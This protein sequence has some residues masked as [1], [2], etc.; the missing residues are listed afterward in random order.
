MTELNTKRLC[1]VH[2]H[3][4]DFEFDTAENFLDLLASTG[5]TDTALQALCW[6]SPVENLSVL[7]QKANY[8]KMKLSAFGSIHKIDLYKD[9]PFEKQAKALFDMGCDGIKLLG[10]KP[11]ERKV[12]GYGINDKRFDKMFSMMEEMG[13]PVLIHV[14]DP[15]KFWDITQMTEHEISRGWYYGEGTGYLSKQEIYDETFK[16]LDKHPNLKVCLAHFFF[17]SNFI[18]ESIRIMEKYPNVSF[19]LT[20]GWEMFVGFTPKIDEWHDFFEK[21]SDRIMYGTDS[22]TYKDNNPE[23]HE[24]V[25]RAI[26]HDKTEFPMPAFDGPIIKGLELTQPTI[27]KIC[28][29]NYDKFVG[30]IQPVK[31][32]KLIDAAQRA[33]DGIKKGGD[34]EKKDRCLVWLEQLLNKYGL[35]Q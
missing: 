12:L 2:V 25:R 5:V 32:D 22:N 8:K 30:S 31:T 1:D 26:T 17:Q 7:Y 20:P 23:I 9:I 11:K 15:E 24:L 19:D 14:N 27:D 16:M 21:Y 29:T 10:Q 28:M 3:M 13:K 6:W 4:R 18:D 33:Y 35:F 34:F